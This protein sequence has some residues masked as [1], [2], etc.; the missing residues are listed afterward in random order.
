MASEAL[1][2]DLSVLVAAVA[3]RAGNGNIAF[4]ASPAQATRIAL[5]AESLSY[6]VMMSLAL[7]AGTVICVALNGLVSAME[8]PEVDASRAATVQEDNSAPSAD[9][10]VGP[11]RSVWQ[12][13]SVA[14][15]LR[16]P[17]SW[18]VRDPAAVSFVTGMKW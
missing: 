13:D 17:V 7:P 6:P 18:V 10:T 11:R 3:S 2:A 16:M 14:L 4:V 5:T 9:P 1:T 15:K 12:T 8:P